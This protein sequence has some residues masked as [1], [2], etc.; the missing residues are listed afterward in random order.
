MTDKQYLTR[1][2]ASEY[3]TD[4]KGLP[5]SPKTL[6]KLATVGGSP[7]Y[8]KFGSRRVV[9]EVSAL[10]KWVEGKLSAPLSNSS[11]ELET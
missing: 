6:A 3:L 2:E 4:I 9:Y 10:D 1:L 5:T 8:R 11:Q 7:E